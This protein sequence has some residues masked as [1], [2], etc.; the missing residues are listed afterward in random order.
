MHKLIL[1]IFVPNWQNGSDPGVRSRIGAVSGIFGILCN[2]VLFL[3][4]LLAGIFSGS[5]AV[6]AD[7]VNNL[8]DAASSIVTLI[9]FKLASK[10]ADKDHPFGHARYEYIA[11]LTVAALIIFIGFETGKS[12]L[13]KILSPTPVEYTWPVLLVLAGAVLLKLWMMLFNRFLGKHIASQAL[14]ATAADS[15][16]DV[17][18]TLAVLTAALV[19]HFTSWRIDGIMGMAVALFILYSGVM[20]ARD[21][22][23]PL[24]GE[25]ASPQLRQQLLELVKKEPKVLGIHDLMV[26][27]YGPGQRFASLH[28]EMDQREDPLLCHELID[29]LERECLEKLRVHLVIH[30]DPVVTG[31]A[32]QDEMRSQVLAAL[33]AQD[34]RLTV[35]DFRMVRGAGHSNL[36][37]DV[38][39]PRDLEKEQKQIKRQLDDRLN[40]QNETMIYTVITFD[41]AEE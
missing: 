25:A 24:L 39:L 37:F 40:E 10:P 3:A 15:R 2:C 17:I 14:L 29:D 30:Y 11:G 34:S 8:S 19:Q 16:N 7:A 18:S 20:L 1:R 31:D 23:S 35:H 26:H 36:I 41:P 33:Q 22:I 5:V 4:K 12:S 6:I 28:V 9:G 21:T 32:E 13:E 27:D 38:S